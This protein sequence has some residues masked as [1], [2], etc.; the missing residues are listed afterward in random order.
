[1]V[2]DSLVSFLFATN[3]LSD[4]FD[5]QLSGEKKDLGSDV[6]WGVVV[7]VLVNLLAFVQEKLWLDVALSGKGLLGGFVVKHIFQP[8]L[9]DMH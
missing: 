4:M 6:P 2:E 3:N 1:M 8:L 5:S 9:R 7:D